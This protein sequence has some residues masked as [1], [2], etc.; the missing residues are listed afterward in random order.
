MREEGTYEAIALPRKATLTGLFAIAYNR[1][2]THGVERA[3][4]S[5]I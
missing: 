4:R 3:L 5:G 2:T 1:G